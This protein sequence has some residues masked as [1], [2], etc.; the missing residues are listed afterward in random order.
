MPPFS[1]I[2]RRAWL[3][4]ILSKPRQ[5]LGPNQDWGSSKEAISSFALI[6][7]ETEFFDYLFFVSNRHHFQPFFS[8]L[9]HLLHSFQST[10][11]FFGPL[12]GAVSGALLSV[13][14]LPALLAWLYLNPNHKPNLW[15]KLN[16]PKLS[17]LHRGRLIDMM[18]TDPFDSRA[19]T[20][21]TKW[22]ISSI[23]EK[24]SMLKHRKNND[25]DIIL[26]NQPMSV[27]S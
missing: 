22:R 17:I 19:A 27:F 11:F 21:W 10:Y 2:S 3:F 6:Y 12:D 1:G 24:R 15:R 26:I 25:L 13:R 7:E 16:L 8:L 14:N 20:T 9:P 18:N 5:A 4:Y 23:C